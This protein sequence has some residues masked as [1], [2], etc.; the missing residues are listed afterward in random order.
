MPQERLDLEALQEAQDYKAR[1]DQ[2]DL[3]EMWEHLD[4]LVPPDLE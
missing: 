2:L 3:K 4:Q 1:L